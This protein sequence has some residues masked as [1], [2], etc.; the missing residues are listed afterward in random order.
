MDVN[1][2]TFKAGGIDF[3]I[4]VEE[5]QEV[6]RYREAHLLPRPLP[7]V[8]GVFELRNKLILL[9]DIQK[10]FGLA[11]TQPTR[12]SC[13]VVIRSSHGF[14]GLLV[15]SLSDFKR[16]TKEH[17]TRSI[18]LAGFSED[19][20]KGVYLH[21]DEIILLPNFEKILFSFVRIKLLPINPS[22]H[23][24]FRYKSDKGHLTQVLEE[25]HATQKASLSIE[26]AQ[27]LARS[28]KLSMAQLFKMTSFYSRFR[29]ESSQ[30]S[31]SESLE[32]TKAGDQKYLQLSL[33]LEEENRK[34]TVTYGDTEFDTEAQEF[35]E[36]P[37]FTSADSPK[38]SLLKFYGKDLSIIQYRELAQKIDLPATQL[39]RFITFYKGKV[40]AKD[41][42]LSPNP[43][44][45]STESLQTLLSDKNRSLVEVLLAIRERQGHFTYENMRQISQ[46]RNIPTTQIYK[47]ASSLY[48]SES[49][50]ETEALT[51][52]IN[53]V[54]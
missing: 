21:E 45:S 28:L 6:I 41:S 16:I 38:D 54:K 43:E 10:R 18:S 4:R 26:Q 22:D 20:L 3:G 36:S 35:V 30:T 12:N 1:L 7:H 14:I 29:T 39:A 32:V 46:M 33:R 23:F 34:R 19:L 48:G 44:L 47:L 24:A 37:D 53:T 9:I 25:I 51:K 42:L 11:S 15:E 13:I 8:K 49:F 27:T 52:D 5:V 50:L 31:S 17:M 40:S 2:I